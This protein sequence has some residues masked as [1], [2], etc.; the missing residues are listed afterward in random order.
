MSSDTRNRSAVFRRYC[1]PHTCVRSRPSISS[2]LIERLSPRCKTLPARIPATSS[3]RATSCGSA[4]WP[5]YR[6]EEL[7]ATTFSPGSCDRRLMTR[8][9]DAIGQVVLLRI[10]AGV[11]QRQDCY[12]RDPRWHA[13]G[14]PRVRGIAGNE[15][16]EDDQRQP[17]RMRYPSTAAALEGSGAGWTCTPSSAV[18]T[19]AGTGE[20][21]FG[22]AGQTAQN[23]RFPQRIDVRHMDTRARRRL[24]QAFDGH[25]ERGFRQRTAR[26]R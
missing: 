3:A 7:L 8:F 17:P 11:P 16:R 2:T 14:E 23:R 9:A 13:R 6:D 4:S 19:S 21:V 10:V 26:S 18:T 22:P 20:A 1:S 15:G 24:V 12:R 25:L 5:L